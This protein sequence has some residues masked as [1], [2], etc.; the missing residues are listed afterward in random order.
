MTNDEKREAAIAS[1]SIE[2]HTIRMWVASHPGATA[3][4]IRRGI[5]GRVNMALA[6]MQAMDLIRCEKTK[7]ETG[8]ALFKWF[9]IPK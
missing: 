4:E 5:G 2:C 1:F 9:V 7:S 8:R 6:K 3:L